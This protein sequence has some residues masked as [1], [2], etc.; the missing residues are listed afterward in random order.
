M[1]QQCHA[2]GSEQM[3]TEMM[4]LEYTP[5]FGD[6]IEYQVP[7]VTCRACGESFEAEGAAEAVRAAMADADRSSAKR[8]V[9]YLEKQRL[10]MAYIERVL[11]LAPRTIF[12]WKSGEMS[13]AGLALLRIVRTYP[14]I[15][16]VAGARFD[17]AVAKKILSA[18]AFNTKNFLAPAG[19]C[20]DKANAAAQ[21]QA[22]VRVSV[23]A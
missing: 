21:P 9:E 15:L 7:A 13:A 22:N 11:G 12:R 17:Q 2:C 1:A 4:S 16:R 18:E 10:S 19:T 3:D 23:A 6:A 8:I 5:P 14:W 20:S